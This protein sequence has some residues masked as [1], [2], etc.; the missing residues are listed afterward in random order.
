MV[1]NSGT[2]IEKV[3]NRQ[4]PAE[5]S[6]AVFVY[7][8]ALEKAGSFE[9]DK[10]RSAISAVKMQTCY[11]NISFDKTGK[12]IAKPMVLRQIQG[13]KYIPVA[14]TKFATGKFKPGS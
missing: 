4:T 1:L 10:V 3:T 11:G 9:T 13:G 12:N 8:K 5:S 14:P 2:P 6:A 7:A